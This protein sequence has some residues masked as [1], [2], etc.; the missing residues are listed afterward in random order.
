[1][2][3]D[4]QRTFRV[5]VSHPFAGG[6]RAEGACGDGGTGQVVVLALSHTQMLSD[7]AALLQ[8]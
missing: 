4:H 1:M 3:S 6:E 8:E 2:S 5:F 7:N